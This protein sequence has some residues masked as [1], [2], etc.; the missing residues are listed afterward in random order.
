MGFPHPVS[1][2]FL[3]D[4]AKPTREE[5]IQFLS[6]LSSCLAF[7]VS[8]IQCVLQE[9]KGSET[10]NFQLFETLLQ[11]VAQFFQQILSMNTRV[12]VADLFRFARDS[13][14]RMGLI[15]GCSQLDRALATL[16]QCSTWVVSSD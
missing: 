6:R 14:A 9:P 12:T 11:A 1:L 8:A 7:V 3:E 13:N 16:Q 5:A 4:L 15:Q 10:G 2:D